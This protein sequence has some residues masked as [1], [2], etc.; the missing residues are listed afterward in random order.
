MCRSK[1]ML[2]RDEASNWPHN[3]SSGAP[4]RRHALFEGHDGA[5]AVAVSRVLDKLDIDTMWCPGPGDGHG[6]RCPLVEQGHCDLLDKADFVINNLGESNSARAAVAP[7]VDDAVH[8]DRQVVVLTG[9]QQAES[10]Q[11]ALPGSKVV[12]GPLTTQIVQ[13]VARMTAGVADVV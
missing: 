8:G 9:W 1:G 6:P 5:E 7:A 11:T 13:D 10:L 4:V 12:E 2:G 3:H